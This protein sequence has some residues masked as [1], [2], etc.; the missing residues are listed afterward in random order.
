MLE[1]D[2]KKMIQRH[3]SYRPYVYY[4]S[5]GFP[6]GGYGHCFYDRSPISHKVAVL[7]FEDDFCVA[8]KSYE[9]LKLDLD[10]VRRAVII[11]ML[12]NLGLPRFRKFKKLLRSLRNK[13]YMESKKEMLDSLW[14]QQ[15]GGRAVEL[16][17]MMETGKKP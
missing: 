3:E 10:P 17:E 9:K 13:D 16:A 5:R 14:A 2:I 12:Y 11:D 15:V 7:L 1:D 8:Q 6:T 4:D